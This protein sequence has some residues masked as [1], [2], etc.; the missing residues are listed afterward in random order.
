MIPNLISDLSALLCSVYP[1]ASP[2]WSFP[3]HGS[4]LTTRNSG[5]AWFGQ[6]NGLSPPAHPS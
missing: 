5:I 6:G 3:L 4:V 2:L 1:D